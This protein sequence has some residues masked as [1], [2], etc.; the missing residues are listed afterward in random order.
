[1]DD[2]LPEWGVSDVNKGGEYG[3]DL[4]WCQLLW[5]AWTRQIEIV[6]HRKVSS[7]F[8]NHRTLDASDLEGSAIEYHMGIIS[9]ATRAWD[10]MVTT[11]EVQTVDTSPPLRTPAASGAPT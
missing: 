2:A 4:P 1:M 3:H 5:M 7:Q 10:G 9:D 11:R 8:C 6:G